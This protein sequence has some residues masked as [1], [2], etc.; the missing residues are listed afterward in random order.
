M[1]CSWLTSAPIWVCTLHVLRPADHIAVTFTPS[2]YLEYPFA[3]IATCLAL[4]AYDL[5]P[6][7]LIQSQLLPHT[8][9]VLSSPCPTMF[10]D[11]LALYDSLSLKWS[12]LFHLSRL[13]C[14]F[15]F[16]IGSSPALQI[17][18]CNYD[19]SPC[20]PVLEAVPVWPPNPLIA[21]MRISYVSLS[22]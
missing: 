18:R 7:L 6:Q 2:P 1:T 14:F 5:S 3:R 10:S 19:E 17:S 13:W 12:S 8:L 22:L 21:T 15:D 11:V 20:S 16:R 9:Q 4:S